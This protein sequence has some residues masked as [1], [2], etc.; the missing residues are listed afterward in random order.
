MFADIALYPEQASTT[1]TR[2]DWL[3]YFLTGVTGS[4]GLLVAVLLI[5]FPCVIA[6]ARARRVCRRRRTSRR[7]W[8]GSG[9]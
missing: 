5:Y 3:F 2:V 1:A 8:N 7:P 6:G 4:V 9:P